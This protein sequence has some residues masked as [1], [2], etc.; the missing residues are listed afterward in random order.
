MLTPL[1]IEAI[2]IEAWENMFDAASPAFK[3][4]MNMYYV[5][6][7][8]GICLV[9]GK[10]PV[11]HFNM[12]MGLGLSEPITKEILQ[13]VEAV[14]EKA[15]QYAYMIH[16]FE[17]MQPS[18][19]PALFEEMGY[20][21]KGGWERIIWKRQPIKH[22]STQR[23]ITVKLVNESTAANWEK[24]VLDIYQYPAHDW[25][26]SL[27]NVKGWNHFL[28]YENGKIVACRS[29]YTGKNNLAWTG[30]DT[31]VPIVMTND[32]L[33]DRILFEHMQQYCIDNGVEYLMADIEVPSPERNTLIYKQF[34]ELGFTVEYLRKL[35]R[36]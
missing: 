32:L 36:K 11:V 26:K 35:Y 21:V 8:G 17:Q 22:I 19:A 15:N 27:W 25:L 4:Q 6:V 3:E 30:I 18:N 31:P 20:C 12:I 7:G 16:Y 28:A 29:M 14:Y 10:Y 2:E 34:N 13:K 24:F 23:N 1:Q 33:P 9:F 5:K